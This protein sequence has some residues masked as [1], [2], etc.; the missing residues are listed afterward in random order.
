MTNKKI[1]LKVVTRQDL[2]NPHYKLTK[3]EALKKAGIK[4]FNGPVKT[5]RLKTG[6]IIV[7]PI[8]SGEEE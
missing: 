4:P 2:S 8:S 7:K 1:K 6:K 3:A 5:I